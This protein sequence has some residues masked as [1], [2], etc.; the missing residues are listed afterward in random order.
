VAWI[1]LHEV[2]DRESKT[3]V[4]PNGWWNGETAY[5]VEQG[6]LG[7]MILG[8]HPE[9]VEGELT[10][11]DF[12]VQAHRLIFDAIMAVRANAPGGP[13]LRLVTHELERQGTLQRAGGI[14]YV[15]ALIDKLPDIQNVPTYAFYV[16][17]AARYRRL[18]GIKP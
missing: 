8:G 5:L 6:L 13:D 12:M 9:E 1:Q 15:T 7:A 18:K 17:E 3:W 16:R 14:S 4:L 10:S 11:A 2:L